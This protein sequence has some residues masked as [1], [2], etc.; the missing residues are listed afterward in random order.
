MSVAYE[1]GAALRLWAQ[2]SGFRTQGRGATTGRLGEPVLAVDEIQGNVLAGF[3][4][5]YQALLFFRIT[6]AERCKRALLAMQ[7]EIATLRE[8]IAFNRLRKTIKR[9]RDNAGIQA[10]WINVALS[11]SGLGKLTNQAQFHDAAFREGM[12]RRSQLLGDPSSLED[13]GN[14][15][16]WLVG[17][18]TTLPDLLVIVAS[19]DWEALKKTGGEVKAGLSSGAELIH[20]DVGT[21][22]LT[23]F[24]ASDHF[25][26]RDGISQPGVRG[27]VSDDPADFLTPR[28]NPADLDQGKPGQ[29]LIWPG[30]F[31]F[32]YPGQNS[33][34][35]LSPG[36]VVEG[37][38]SWAKNGSFLV[39]RRYRQDVEKFKDFLA[40]MAGQL[41]QS[42]PRLA[43]ITGE[44]LG[45]K[46]VGRWASGAPLLRAL[47][48][49]LPAMA[50]DSC[51]DN[52]FDYVRPGHPLK[53]GEPGKC[54]DHV[55]PP[56]PGDERGLICPHAAHIRKAF[57]RDD[58]NSSE[59]EAFVQRHRLLRRGIPFGH[60]E[61]AECGLLFLSYQTSIERQFE[62]V[63]RNWLNN[64]DFRERGS[65]HDPIAG[66]SNDPHSRERFFNLP[67][68]RT[69]GQIEN[70]RIEL[71]ADFVI[72]T[73]GAYFFAPSISALRQLTD[74]LISKP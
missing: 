55:F 33:E 1:L 70:V 68:S 65:G 5:D 57:P 56:A 4:K 40:S 19:D 60:P 35:K 49:D 43:G 32:G 26:F 9:R 36:P 51:A 58:L 10:T 22:L 18:P 62:F 73:G 67:L 6:D 61:T 28:E 74:G 16:N 50:G 44:L 64:P 8:V 34:D 3:N 48:S 25:G 53:G 21:S 11:S 63:I 14:C 24:R 2:H 39:Y 71:P 72:P 17:A 42:H 59:G 47:E 27:L 38:P 20:A 13:E 7:G 69:D 66:Q 37:G 29:D 31:V 15:V 45:A 54:T 12:H 30:E 52:N 41:A 23:P 46:L